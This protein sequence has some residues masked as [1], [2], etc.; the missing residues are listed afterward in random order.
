MKRM[1]NYLNQYG[2]FLFFASSLFLA[3][4][5]PL[6]SSNEAYQSSNVDEFNFEDFDFGPDEVIIDEPLETTSSEKPGLNIYLPLIG[7]RKLTSFVDEKTKIAGLKIVLSDKTN[8]PSIGNLIIEESE[9]KFVNGALSI[10]GVLTLLGKQG[11]FS[12]TQIIFE[13]K[14]VELPDGSAKTK[15]V[16]KRMILNCTFVDKPTLSL[17]KD[18]SISL[19][20]IDITLEREKPAFLKSTSTILGRPIVVDI[21]FT[22]KTTSAFF[23]IPDNTLLSVIV[24]EVADT[25]LKTAVIKNAKLKLNNIYAKKAPSESPKS[26]ETDKEKE[27]K[28]KEEEAKRFNAT[29]NGIVSLNNDALVESEEAEKKSTDFKLNGTLSGKGVDFKLE[30]EQIPIK[31]LG[32]LEKSHL[33]INTTVNP[34]VIKLMGVVAIQLPDIDPLTTSLAIELTKKE[35]AVSGEVQKDITYAGITLKKGKLDFD[36]TTKTFGIKGTISIDDIIFQVRLSA[37]NDPKEPSKKITIF[38]AE[39]KS[40]EFTPFKNKPGLDSLKVTELKGI[41]LVKKTGNDTKKEL[42]LTGNVNFFGRDLSSVIKFIENENKEKGIYINAPLVKNTDLGQILPGLNMPPFNEI[43]LKE[44]AFQACS[45]KYT[46]T[47][48]NEKIPKG[49]SIIAH[50]PL[51]GPLARA[52]TISGSTDKEFI[53]RGSI[54]MNNPKDSTFSIVVSK[55][56]PDPTKPFSLGEIAL[57]LSGKPSVNLGTGLIYKPVNQTP[58]EFKGIFDF[59]SDATKPLPP[60]ITLTAM[61][62]GKWKNAFGREGWLVEDVA[63]LIGIMV[64]SPYVPTE[65]GGTGRLKIKELLDMRTAFKISAD[66]SKI[67]FEAESK[68]DIS[69]ANTILLA[70]EVLKKDIPVTNVPAFIIKKDAL[71]KFATTSI[72]IGNKVISPGIAA[73]GEMDILGT[74]ANLDIHIGCDDLLNCGF[75][76]FASLDPINIKNIIKI[77]GYQ[78]KALKK[79][80]DKP[81]LDIEFTLQ[82]QYVHLSGMIDIA[83]IIKSKSLLNFSNEGITFD[84]EDAIGGNTLTWTDTEGKKVPLL[85]A[86]VTG[87]SSGSL[88]DPNFSL[89]LIFKNYLKQYLINQISQGL[90]TAKKEISNAITIAQKE[91]DTVDNAIQKINKKFASAHTDVQAGK[92]DYGKRIDDVRALKDKK[93]EDCRGE[94]EKINKKISDL[95]KWYNNLPQSLPVKE[96]EHLV[97]KGKILETK[98]SKA[99][100]YAAKQT[101]LQTEKLAIQAKCGT[102]QAGLSIATET[103]KGFEGVIDLGHGA[104][105]VGETVSTG[106]LKGSAATS[107]AILEGTK[108]ATLLSISAAKLYIDFNINQIEINEIAW[109]GSMYELKDGTL[110][111]V[112]IVVTVLGKQFPLS[113]TLSPK[114]GFNQ[115]TKELKSVAK[116][117]SDQIK[118]NIFDPIAN[119]LKKETKE[120]KQELK[121]VNTN[122]SPS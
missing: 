55:G 78:D 15:N 107:K 37:G 13:D 111:N 119:T 105:N 79:A 72:E 44:A 68:E 34:S 6:Y 18:K 106:V 14:E 65:V 70:G 50:V 86:R 94:L 11:I 53:L 58:L 42:G 5:H 19:D 64:G 69:L 60:I 47:E 31:G 97:V 103:Q 109:R 26:T 17:G 108:Q 57:A 92:E 32:T 8:R 112:S 59:S 27:Q 74:V 35:V 52:S 54:D 33:I 39:A 75:K 25:P 56:D 10:E 48:T 7:Q 24:P 100:E 23:N 1:K 121:A 66:I 118:N 43:I 95:N 87:K 49:V 12:A 99:G 61:M 84:F 63:L 81:K 93:N 114:K 67:G 28:E 83:G 89:E 41:I 21:A 40:N 36:P 38:H 62:L 85:Y 16:I 90:D 122:S 30:A 98:G 115:V 46:D 102:I 110:S 4:F 77:T 2:T 20:A 113:V 22:K 82:Q 88:S 76:A 117:I 80:V 116:K 51:S 101:A 104:L 3:S 96:V 9:I 120:L 91:I 73:K 29:I 45:I 71:I